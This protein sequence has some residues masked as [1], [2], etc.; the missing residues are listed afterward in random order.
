VTNNEG[1][2]W[3]NKLVF[4]IFRTFGRYVTNLRGTFVENVKK[5][6]N[7]PTLVYSMCFCLSIFR[8]VETGNGLDKGPQHTNQ[9]IKGNQHQNGIF[10]EGGGGVRKG[11]EI[12]KKKLRC[13][14]SAC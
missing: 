13:I 14:S 2:T 7:Q 3:S 12:N 9:S 4:A 8:A 6:Q 1:V 5:V 11:K 10:P